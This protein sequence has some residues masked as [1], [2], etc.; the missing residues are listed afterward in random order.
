MGYKPDTSTLHDRPTAHCNK[1][2][3]R[4][5]LQEKLLPRRKLNPA[6]LRLANQ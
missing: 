5:E 6:L 1:P 3:D 4:V 2:R